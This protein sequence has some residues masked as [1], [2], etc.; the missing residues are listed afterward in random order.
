MSR[1]IKRLPSH[2]TGRVRSLAIYAGFDP[3][4]FKVDR[5]ESETGSFRF[6][7]VEKDPKK[8]KDLEY[9]LIGDGYDVLSA[10]ESGRTYATMDGYTRVVVNFPDYKYMNIL[11]T[12]ATHLEGDEV[13]GP[14]TPQE[15]DLLA[16]GKVLGFL[17]QASY[18]LEVT[19]KYF[20]STG[21]Y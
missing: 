4:I 20:L 2:H 7:T 11:S 3:N 18:G 6:W 17:K 13:V 19:T 16:V 8:L 5:G 10:R 21:D 15:G 9:M 12:I 1:V 14:I